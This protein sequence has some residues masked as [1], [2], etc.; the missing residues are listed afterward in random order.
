MADKEPRGLTPKELQELATRPSTR[1]EPQLIGR[2]NIPNPFDK[3]GKKIESVRNDL[4]KL[5]YPLG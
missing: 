2:R 3:L 5:L 1:N 4:G